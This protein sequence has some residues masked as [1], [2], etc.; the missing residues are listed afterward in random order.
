MLILA[1]VRRTGEREFLVAET[2][3]IRGTAFDQRQRL[4][5]LA[6]R[7][8]ENTGFDIAELEHDLSIPIDCD[9]RAAMAAFDERAAGDFDSD[10]IGHGQ[11]SGSVW[12]AKA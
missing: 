12:D 8:R 3:G 1:I 9:H 4:H 10:G 2:V 11:E 6:G 7:T 5:G